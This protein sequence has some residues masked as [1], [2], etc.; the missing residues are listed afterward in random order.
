MGR[1]ALSLAF[2]VV[3]AFAPGAG[4]S[5]PVPVT[6][7]LTADFSGPVIQGTFTASSPLCLSGTFVTEVVG[8]GGGPRAFAMT[9]RQHMTCDDGS[10]SF[11]IQFHPQSNPISP[12]PSGPWAALGGTGSYAGLHGTGSFSVVDFPSPA[13]VVAVFTG[14]VHFD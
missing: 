14:A 10:G 8:G 9:G 1:L 13:T 12:I 2:V 3:F 6:M 4:A 5:P 7:T 11:V